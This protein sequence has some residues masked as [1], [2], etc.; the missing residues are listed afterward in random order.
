MSRKEPFAKRVRFPK[1]ARWDRR[2]LENVIVYDGGGFRFL[3]VRTEDESGWVRGM[4]NPCR[5]G[6]G[7]GI[8]TMFSPLHWIEGWVGFEEKGTNE[9]DGRSWHRSSIL[10]LSSSMDPSHVTK[11]KDIRDPL[12][13]HVPCLFFR[14]DPFPIVFGLMNQGVIWDRRRRTKGTK[15]MEPRT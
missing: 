15:P 9:D 6:M 4:G 12:D 10:F 7:Q 8:L 11:R 2:W 14:S 3:L 1:C 5:M 13:S